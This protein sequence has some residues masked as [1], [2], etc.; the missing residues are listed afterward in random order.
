MF[1]HTVMPHFTEKVEKAV[2][3]LNSNNPQD[4]DENEFID[5]SR[6]VY[7]GVRDVR[8]AVLMNRVRFSL[9]G[10][11]TIGLCHIPVF[12]LGI[13]QHMHKITNL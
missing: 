6:M 13:S 11:Y 9:K 5:A 1:M 3:S 10:M 7:D 12:S 4:M 8:R 2:S